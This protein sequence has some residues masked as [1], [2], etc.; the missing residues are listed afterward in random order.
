MCCLSVKGVEDIGLNFCS[1][2]WNK[3]MAVSLK[4]E[5]TYFSIPSSGGSKRKKKLQP[6]ISNLG[7]LQASRGKSP[8]SFPLLWI[9]YGEKI[10]LKKFLLTY[11]C[12]RTG[13]DFQCLLL[14][15]LMKR[16]RGSMT[17]RRSRYWGEQG[18]FFKSKTTVYIE[19]NLLN[20]D[21][22]SGPVA[23]DSSFIETSVF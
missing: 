7:D 16:L 21:F 2:C 22:R 19:E 5:E 11:G 10:E 3:T 13:G 15:F 4:I 18:S 1:G 17:K 23:E 6:R 14:E 12:G 9:F 8:T 20:L